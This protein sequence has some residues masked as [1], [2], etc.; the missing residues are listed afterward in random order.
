M[1]WNEPDS[2][3]SAIA[4]WCG[5]CHSFA[6]GNDLTTSSGLG[7]TPPPGGTMLEN[8]PVRLTNFGAPETDQFNTH[9][10]KVKVMSEIGMWDL[11]GMDVTPT[12]TSC[13]RAHGNGNPQG[14]IFRS[15][16]GALSEDGDSGG[17]SVEDLCLQCHV[18]GSA[19][20]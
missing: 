18:G 11:V 7:S 17:S 5:G 8:H 13:H 10:N 16:N 2:S 1:D 15:G 12:C 20:P 19:G 14:L 9:V 6:H 3:E 4:R